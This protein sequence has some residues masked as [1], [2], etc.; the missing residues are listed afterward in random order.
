M[1]PKEDMSVRSISSRKRFALQ[2]LK[3]WMNLELQLVV[4]QEQESLVS[5]I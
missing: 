3:R 5:E 1:N 4:Q 2:K